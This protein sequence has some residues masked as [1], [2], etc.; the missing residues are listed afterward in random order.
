MTSTTDERYCTY[1]HPA[2]DAAA[3]GGVKAATVG[4][5]TPACVDAAAVAGGMLISSFGRPA[6][7]AVSVAALAVEVAA[8]GAGAGA[9]VCAF[10]VVGIG[11]VIFTVLGVP[12]AACFMGVLEALPWPSR[13]RKSPPEV[14]LALAG[15]SPLGNDV[16]SSDGEP[17][18]AAAAA[19]DV[20]GVPVAEGVA[21]LAGCGASSSS[22]RSR[23]PPA[24]SL[25]VR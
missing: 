10:A 2:E 20:A 1:F 23:L 8:A 11:V 5:L 17:T 3:A 9:G 18:A 24:R 13:R 6:G 12:P 25:R 14:A 16:R 4:V 21:L 7:G 19:V 22:D 15:S